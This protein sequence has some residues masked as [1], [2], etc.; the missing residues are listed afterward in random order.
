MIIVSMVNFVSK[1]IIVCV[2]SLF[3]QI[4]AACVVIGVEDFLLEFSRRFQEKRR[5]REDFDLKPLNPPPTEHLVTIHMEK[6]NGSG[7]ELPFSRRLLPGE[8]SVRIFKVY[9]PDHIFFTEDGDFSL[10]NF[11]EGIDTNTVKVRKATGCTRTVGIYECRGNKICFKEWPEAPGVENAVYR[12]FSAAHSIQY[13]ENL[14]IPASEG[15]LMNGKVFL[16]S[17]F[18]E[19]ES[20][21]SIL[22]KVSENPDYAS[23]Y[24]FDLDKFQALVIFCLIIAPEDCRPENIL[25]RPIKGSSKYEF[26]LIDN[27]RSFGEQITAFHDSGEGLGLIRTRMH[28]ALFCFHEMLKHKINEDTHR[29]ITSQQFA[30]DILLAVE[31]LRAISVY[32]SALAAHVQDGYLEKSNLAIPFGKDAIRGMYERF[33]RFRTI[34]SD[35]NRSLANI[36]VAASPEISRIYE[37]DKLDKLDGPYI[38]PSSSILHLQSQPHA[39]TQVLKRLCRIDARRFSG[40]TPLSANVPLFVYFGSPLISPTA[41]TAPRSFPTALASSAEHL[42]NGSIGGSSSMSSR[43]RRFAS[44]GSTIRGALDGQQPQLDFL[45]VLLVGSE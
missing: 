44:S 11:E 39:L 41:T 26:A 14:P 36:I 29:R 37:L 22:T 25:V 4:N 19:G 42:S 31:E 20:L 43:A 34:A 5:L 23:K 3:M 13:R 10:R 8:D 18:M 2:L 1:I 28:C 9:D 40:P 38:P 6:F 27:E 21:K 16:I 45:E 15:I 17:E 12:M 30:D 24:N 7:H 32:L 35:R 33:G